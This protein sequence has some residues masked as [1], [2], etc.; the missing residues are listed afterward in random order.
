[1]YAACQGL[2]LDRSRAV[3]RGQDDEQQTCII[4]GRPLGGLILWEREGGAQNIGGIKGMR[5]VGFWPGLHRAL[6]ISSLVGLD[7]GWLRLTMA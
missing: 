5:G 1:M 2:G 4:K 7:L 6:L 3:E